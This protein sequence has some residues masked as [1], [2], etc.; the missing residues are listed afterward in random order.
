MPFVKT[1]E[2]PLNGFDAVP[3]SAPG[4]FFFW[5]TETAGCW[6]NGPSAI[7][8]LVR[9]LDALKL[10]FR[11]ASDLVQPSEAETGA[12]RTVKRYRSKLAS[13]EEE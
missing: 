2:L 12:K 7:D 10:L 8:D 4:P 1:D 3:P 6:P 9:S 5:P 11:P 13:E